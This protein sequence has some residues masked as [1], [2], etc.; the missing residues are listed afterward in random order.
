MSIEILYDS[1]NECII[2]FELINDNKEN[3]EILFK[4]CNHNNNYHNECINDWINDCID[5][6]INPVCPI[7]SNELEII[8]INN[9]NIIESHGNYCLFSLSLSLISI[10]ILIFYIN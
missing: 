3:K 8:N 10:I 5:K 7:C 2:C 6:N 9:S 1:N 4:N